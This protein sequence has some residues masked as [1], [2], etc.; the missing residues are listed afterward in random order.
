MIN[1][2]YS[3]IK[4]K[5]N[6]F[7]TVTNHISGSDYWI[8]EKEIKKEKTENTL[9]SILPEKII[10][11]PEEARKTN[12]LKIIGFSIAATTVLTAATIFFILQGGPKGAAKGFQ[13]L[14]EFIEK[15]LQQTKLAG[16]SGSTHYEYLL[17]KIDF[18]LG[19]A[20]AVNNFTTIKDFT[21][22]KL[23]YGGKLNLKYTRKIHEGITN[24]FEK[25]GL[26]TISNSYSKTSKRFNKVHE[27]NKHIFAELEKSNDLQK[28][29]TINGI[30]K[31]KQ[32]WIALAK[33]YTTETE[34]L[35]KDNFSEAV[36]ETR[37]LKIKKY[38]KELEQSFDTK[39]PLW[40]FSKDILK[41]FVAEAKMM[42][43]KLQIQK[44]IK[45]IRQ[46]M[47]FDE[48]DLYN[49]ADSSILK[50]SSFL[51]TSD[52]KSLELLNKIRHNFRAFS[53]GET[54][55]FDTM[56]RDLEE[57]NISVLKSQN[58]SL[59]EK[60]A[61]ITHLEDLKSNYINYKRGLIQ[62]I[63][64]IM[65]SL[66]PKQEYK[67][68]IRN[69]QKA[70]SSLDK[71]I[72]LETE[73]FINKSRDLALGSAPTDIITVLGGLGTLAYYLGKSDNSQERTAITLKYGIPALVG[74]GVSLYGNARL[75]A[76]SKSLM[77]A[78]ISSVLANRIGSYANKIY[79]NSLK[80]KGKYIEPKKEVK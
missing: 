12:N 61:I 8:G 32:E 47:S 36:R 72:K 26:K 11:N 71:S 10:L 16:M 5:P 56:L 33:H 35:F 3:D 50:I 30:T 18:L 39:G 76:G 75:F 58:K 25:L 21:F 68:I 78:T 1:N 67:T 63:S 66:L 77:F 13:K 74:I 60:K 15:K 44:R 20:E 43:K 6:P 9:D 38:T 27:T 7:G 22:K 57:L 80:K 28:Q 23:M 31:T 37:Y 29:I 19:K 49:T 45:D 46:K 41:T 40:F 14:R 4:S 42:P 79:E 64:E 17:G 2:I 70:L 51:S 34:E 62:N 65:K 52:K 24:L 73:D 69:Y 59:S 48:N 53:K 54:I 55:D